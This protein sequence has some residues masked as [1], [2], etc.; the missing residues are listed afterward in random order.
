MPKQSASGTYVRTSIS[1]P[2]ILGNRQFRFNVRYWSSSSSV[3]NN[4]GQDICV[5][6]TA[7]NR[8]DRIILGTLY[9]SSLANY[10]SEDRAWSYDFIYTAPQDVNC[11]DICSF[12]IDKAGDG[13][14]YTATY[15]IVVSQA[16]VTNMH[17]KNVNQTS[18]T[19]QVDVSNPFDE[20]IKLQ[21]AQGG[22]VVVPLNSSS[23]LRTITATINN[24]PVNSSYNR[25]YGHIV[26]N[27]SSSSPYVWGSGQYNI[28]TSFTNMSMPTIS[29]KRNNDDPTIIDVTWTAGGT[30]NKPQGNANRKPSIVV[31]LDGTNDVVYS[32][33]SINLE[34]SGSIQ[35]KNMSVLSKYNVY[36]SYDVYGLDKQYNQKSNIVNIE[37]NTF[38]PYIKVNGNYKKCNEGYIKVNGN[39]K[40]ILKTYIKVNG[41]Y[42]EV[43]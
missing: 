18:C 4:D 32:T 26:P 8:S 19:I 33:N 31:L 17:I 38:N 3:Y 5:Q 13:R 2:T 24:M 12:T 11:F 36:C 34:N 20:E 25:E 22:F 16:K 29:A 39:Y 1:G 27:G 43:R 41:V 21:N 9:G 7:N 28:C 23:S 40:K 30:T 42:K 10:T 6:V 14:F 37:A 35:I 15:N